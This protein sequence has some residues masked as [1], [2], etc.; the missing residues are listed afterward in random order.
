MNRKYINLIVT[1]FFCSLSIQGNAER[2][3][4]L[5]DKV[6][7]SI[8]DIKPFKVNFTQQVFDE[9]ELE[10]EESGE[11]IFKDRQ[12]LKWTYLDPDYKVFL[13]I[14]D[15]YKFYDRDNEQLTIGKVKEKNRQWLWQL[16]FS[17][18]MAG[19]IEPDDKNMKVYLK[20]EPDNL[21]IEIQ[22]GKNFLPVKAIQKDPS[23]ATMV[24]H[25][26]DYKKKIK[27]SDEI[28]KLEVP[29][30]VDIVME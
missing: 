17:E 29:E 10:I 4:S 6:R 26:K 21:D 24:Y 15:D 13:L 27:L 20:S 16:L 12:T 2:V 14:G 3:S 5:I 11:I 19:Y 7:D 23:G 9:D 25:F 8:S 22:I 28:F 18:E 30:D 1:F